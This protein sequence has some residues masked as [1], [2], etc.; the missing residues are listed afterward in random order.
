MNNPLQGSQAPHLV[1]QTD[2]FHHP[3]SFD[4]TIFNN[5]NTFIH[6]QYFDMQLST[7]TTLPSCHS[8]SS[9]LNELS[10]EVSY[11][12]EPNSPTVQ[13]DQSQSD[14]V[15]SPDIIQQIAKEDEW[16]TNVHASTKYINS[17]NKLLR[18]LY[19]MYIHV[20]NLTKWR[21]NDSTIIDLTNDKLVW[22]HIVGFHMNLS[23]ADFRTLNE[24][25]DRIAFVSN[26]C[27]T[28]YNAITQYLQTSHITSNSL[29]HTYLAYKRMSQQ[30]ED[31]QAARDNL[32]NYV[33]QLLQMDD[34]NPNVYGSYEVQENND[35]GL[36][37][38]YDLVKLYTD[39]QGEL[40]CKPKQMMKHFQRVHHR[41]NDVDFGSLTTL[42]EHHLGNTTLEHI[43]TNFHNWLQ[44][45]WHALG[46]QLQ[47]C[48]IL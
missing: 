14:R 40:P 29:K 44:T 26:S 8:F 27:Y 36:K 42:I 15:N 35:V 38:L 31:M 10:G 46:G 48:F 32:Q 19:K 39:S 22:H 4:L 6:T 9:R 1:G 43:T 21:L 28:T 37:W 23:S 18:I 24:L 34:G 11:D 25:C 16:Q 5:T 33:F 17:I 7:N 41:L 13:D 12:P 20:E 3:S 2:N 45:N 47:S 30:L